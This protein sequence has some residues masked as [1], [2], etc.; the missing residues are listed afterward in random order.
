MSIPR[1]N[2]MWAYA[3]TAP[4]QFQRF[5]VPTPEAAELRDGEVLLAARAGGVCGSD[6]PNFRGA[7]FPHPKDR[8][9]WAA[10]VPGFPMHEVA[11]EVLASRHP[12]HEVGSA[13]VGWASGFDGIAEFVVSD[14]DGLFAYDAS[15]PATT[16]VMI[17]PLACVLYAA[18]QLGNIDGATVAVIGQGPIGLLFSHVLKQRGAAHVIGV[19]RIDRSGAAKAFLVD[20]TVTAAADR[21]AAELVTEA[22][23]PNVIV[24]AVGH[25][26]STLRSC[27]DAAA[28]GGQIFYFG[29]PDDVTYPVE[30]MTLLRKNLTLRSGFTIER[31]RVLSDAVGYL[32]ENPDL[33]DTYV[34]DVFPVSDVQ[35]AFDAAI[36]PKQG[37][38][39]IAIDMA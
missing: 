7:R 10:N 24:E 20:E 31:R 27:M 8:G 38:L 18:E 5:Q 2:T 25:Q 36:S 16:A 34:T 1:E 30:M 28:F 17:Q 4:F 9:G 37:Q 32:S 19:D 12:A 14:G 21:W 11:G 22:S 6:L 13:V 15:L 26:I 39:K 3:L 33:I 35:A 29:I 23:R